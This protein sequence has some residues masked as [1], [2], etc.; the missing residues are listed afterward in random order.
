MVHVGRF[1]GAA[2]IAVIFETVEMLP[3]YYV[4]WQ[5]L[6]ADG[7]RQRIAID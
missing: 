2:C 3:V 5:L 6:R 1:C 4:G 7:Y